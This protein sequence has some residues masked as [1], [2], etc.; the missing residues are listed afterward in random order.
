MMFYN[1][2]KE[3]KTKNPS[4]KRIK[5][6]VGTDRNRAWLIDVE[7]ISKY[8]SGFTTLNECEG[9]AYSR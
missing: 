1:N 4:Q 8:C 5:R 3:V 9:E 6:D 2:L 7:I